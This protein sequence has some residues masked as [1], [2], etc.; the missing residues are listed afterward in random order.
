[1]VINRNLSKILAILIALSVLLV[2]STPAES[3]AASKS[4]NNYAK[5]I[6]TSVSKLDKKF[7]KKKTSYKISL[8]ATQSKTVL[9]FKKA[10]KNAKVSVKIGDK[11]W[12]KYS[13]K[14]TVKKTIKVAN[15][16]TVAVK[17][18]VK[19]QNG[20]LKTY[21]VKVSRAKKA[22]APKPVETD[23]FLQKLDGT[24]EELFPVLTSEKYDDYWLEKVTSFVGQENAAT[25]TESLK[26][27]CT[28]KIYGAEAVEAYPDL[29]NA[30][31]NCY[32]ING[33]DR[34]T[35]AGN[36]IS[37]TLNGTSV[38]SHTYTYQEDNSLSGMMDVR[39]YK[40]DD[41]NAGEFTYFL[42][43]PD[44]PSSTYHIEFRYGSDLNALLELISGNYAYWLAA[45]IPVDSNTDFVKSCIDL[46]IEENL[47]AGE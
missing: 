23:A 11:K 34:L 33:I 36:S 18:R 26:T 22:T 8:K 19:A 5:S 39:V 43:C 41:A 6:K 25:Y 32:F 7:S 46:F 1:M 2:F 20:K 45:G 30:R 47:G 38:F 17:Y 16:K 44:T 31:F 3:F 37:G 40:S 14:A 24:Y 13:T 21:T 27:A 4:K 35:F 15:G 42:L 12:T 10:Q 29:E 9:T 28:A